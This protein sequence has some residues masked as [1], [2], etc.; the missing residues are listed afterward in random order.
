MNFIAGPSLDILE[1]QLIAAAS[2]NYIPYAPTLSNYITAGE[3]TTRWTN[4][5]TWY[6]AK[7]HFWLGTG[8]FYLESA[9]PAIPT[10]TLNRFAEYPDPADKWD[11]F[12]QPPTLTINYPSGAPGSY[13][14][15][16]GDNY[17]PNQTA[18]IY[19]NDITLGTAPISA[20]GTFT[21]TLTTEEATEGT[22]LITA[23]VNP[24]ATVKF[25]LDSD[26]EIRPLEGS[27]LT[28]EVPA[29]VAYTFEAYLTL[30]LNRP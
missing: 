12:V 4:L 15:L 6:N 1:N 29:D 2:E 18:T 11:Y 24:S 28:F 13:L 30:I 17:P 3:A 19:L 27:Y 21:F 14:N 20:S 10:L 23:S 26:S 8:P 25:V 16:T 22:Y 7:G 5:T 9:D